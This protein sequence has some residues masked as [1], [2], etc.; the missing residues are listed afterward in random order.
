MPITTISAGFIGILLLI[1]SANVTK[2]RGR[3]KTSVGDGGKAIVG[4]VTQHASVIVSDRR[5]ASAARK[6]PKAAGSRR[7]RASASAQREA[8]A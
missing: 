3:T 4:N 6:T 7:Q 1:L 5:T 8:K 2:W